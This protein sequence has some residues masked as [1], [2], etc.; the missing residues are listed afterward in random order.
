MISQSKTF[1]TKALRKTGL[2]MAYAG[3]F[4][5]IGCAFFTIMS[6][7]LKLSSTRQISRLTYC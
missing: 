3:Y 7:F 2:D 1:D 4:V 6:R 5:Y